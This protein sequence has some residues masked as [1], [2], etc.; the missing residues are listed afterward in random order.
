VGQW[1]AVLPAESA[2]LVPGDAYYVNDAGGQ[3]SNIAPSGSGNLS[4]QVGIALSTTLL[5]VG[6]V[7]PAGTTLSP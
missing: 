7:G 3:I 2:G 4:T 1:D 6:I 5:L